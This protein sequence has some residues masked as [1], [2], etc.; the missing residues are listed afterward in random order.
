MN[1]CSCTLHFKKISACSKVFVVCVICCGENQRCPS[2]IYLYLYVNFKF[3]YVLTRNVRGVPRFSYELANF[4]WRF[5][6]EFAMIRMRYR[7][8]IVEVGNRP[9]RGRIDRQYGRLRHHSLVYLSS[10]FNFRQVAK[11]TRDR[12]EM[13]LE[14][15]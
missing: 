2:M 5:P 6:N 10:Q 4:F 8:K 14:Y 3:N 7:C 1:T 15:Y 9:V 11:G 13:L 12:V